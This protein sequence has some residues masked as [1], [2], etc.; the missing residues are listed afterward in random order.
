[1]DLLDLFRRTIRHPQPDTPPDVGSLPGGRQPAD[2]WRRPPGILLLVGRT[3]DSTRDPYPAREAPIGDPSPAIQASSAPLSP[4]QVGDYAI[5]SPPGSGDDHVLDDLIVLFT[6]SALQRAQLVPR[7]AAIIKHM[8]E[9]EDCQIELAAMLEAS[10]RAQTL[11]AGQRAQLRALYDRLARAMYGPHLDEARPHY[12]RYVALWIDQGRRPEAPSA[13]AELLPVIRHLA[14]HPQCDEA[15]RRLYSAHAAARVRAALENAG[16]SVTPAAIQQPLP[17]EPVSMDVQ[18]EDA[19]AEAQAPDADL[20][21]RELARAENPVVV[22]G[23]MRLTDYETYD[24]EVEHQAAGALTLVVWGHDRL[25]DNKLR[26]LKLLRPEYH[27]DADLRAAFVNAA[28]EWCRVAP[29]GARHAAPQLVSVP[30]FDDAPAIL[31]S[32][33][34]QTLAGVLEAAHRGHHP[35]TPAQ[36]F[37]WAQQIAAALVALHR[38]KRPDGVTPYTHGDLKPENILIGDEATAWLSDVGMHAVWASARTLTSPR[39]HALPN[40]RRGASAAQ[41]EMGAEAA[42]L[43]VRPQVGS[44]GAVV[45][46]PRYM[47]PERWLGVEAAGPAS[48]VYALGIVLFELFSGTGG[49]PFMPHPRSAAGWFAAHETGPNRVLPGA[50]ALTCGPLARTLDDDGSGLSA[51]ERES[52]AR[53]IV[54]QLDGLI[55]RCLEPNPDDRPTAGD[56]LGRLGE[57][58]GRLGLEREPEPPADAAALGASDPEHIHRLARSHGHAGRP[59]PQSDL[60][61]DILP[62]TPSPDLWIS[63]GSALYDRGFADLA[64]RAYEAADGLTPT[65]GQQTDQQ[66][67]PASARAKIL[68]FHRA[69]AYLRL[70]RHDEAVRAYDEALAHQRDHLPALWGATAAQHRIA[71]AASDLD[72]RHDHL[73]QADERARVA[74][75]YT[76]GTPHPKVRDL[77]ERIQ[78]DCSGARRERSASSE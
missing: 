3:G 34:P 24:I 72:T 8:A 2:D 50:E 52:R 12:E 56:V 9:C 71:V 36:A 28:L 46:T 57:L 30:M 37:G 78:R 7:R 70:G 4:R 6:G 35:L 26:T 54:G 77:H 20:H 53:M 40:D 5:Q 51:P 64:L 11:S 58:A 65:H 61:L 73:R 22:E 66:S 16:D 47:A 25:H 10:S 59:D 15:V 55:H 18:A 14:R 29:H 74:R 49:G 27:G 43:F 1:M 39:I 76:H 44:R 48:D 60:L 63:L 69:N 23:G 32:F 41:D 45:G 17:L 67:A 21:W 33:A 62:H 31:V 19:E 75:S 13:P 42:L 68:A 38:Q